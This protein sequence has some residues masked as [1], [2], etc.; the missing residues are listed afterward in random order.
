MRPVR[1]RVQHRFE[2][3]QTSGKRDCWPDPRGTSTSARFVVSWPSRRSCT[4][5]ARP[6]A[7]SSLSKL[8]PVRSSDSSAESE[9]LCSCG[10]H[11]G[12][13]HTRGRA[14]AGSREGADRLARRDRRRGQRSRPSHPRRRHERRQGTGERILEAA[15]AAV[16]GLEFRGRHVGRMGAPIRQLR[17]AEL[18]VG[19]GRADWRGQQAATGLER[20]LA[21]LE[22]LALLLHHRPAGAKA[23]HPGARA[24]GLGD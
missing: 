15:R 12:H 1:V 21:R 3:R 14:A 16:P 6:I 22:P 20:E 2:P 17:A 13:A 19:L 9:R 11:E 7:Y 8:Y 23:S 10:R 18:G 4:S 24:E 5:R